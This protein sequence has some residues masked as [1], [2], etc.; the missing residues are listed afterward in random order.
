MSGFPLTFWGQTEGNQC[1]RLVNLFAYTFLHLYLRESNEDTL[2]GKV[3]MFRHPEVSKY[4]YHTR[5]LSNCL[6]FH[7]DNADYENACTKPSNK[8]SEEIFAL[9]PTAAYQPPLAQRHKA[10]VLTE[11]TPD[12]GFRHGAKTY[13]HTYTHRRVCMHAD[14]YSFWK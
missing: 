1:K 9:T 13:T 2:H 6:G 12:K 10:T 14:G 11:R 7:G 5:L 8:V 4:C 3:Q